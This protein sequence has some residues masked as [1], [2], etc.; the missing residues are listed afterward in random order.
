M[1]KL[2]H[3]PDLNDEEI[4]R[5]V[6]YAKAGGGIDYAFRTMERL[7]KEADALLADFPESETVDAFKSIFSYII[8]RNK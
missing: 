1:N 5:L 3:K 8:T 2:A 6:E 7:R 4:N